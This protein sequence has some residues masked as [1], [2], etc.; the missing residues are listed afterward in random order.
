MN[1]SLKRWLSDS[2][3]PVRLPSRSQRLNFETL[4][5][6]TTPSITIPDV[7]DTTPPVSATDQ[8]SIASGY[9]PQ[10]VINPSNHQQVVTA[11]T[12][13]TRWHSVFRMIWARPGRRRS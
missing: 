3:K 11:Y 5:D 13:G 2:D 8:S 4:E 10:T 6:R 12:P 9:D 1:F 7:P